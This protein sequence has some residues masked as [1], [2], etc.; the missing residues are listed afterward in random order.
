M[1]ILSS[2]ARVRVK[3]LCS[4]R[5]QSYYIS[6]QYT[7]TRMKPHP[8]NVLFLCGVSQF[9]AI[10]REEHHVIKID[11]LIKLTG[12]SRETGLKDLYILFNR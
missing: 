10:C 3:A 8:L 12:L 7:R 1:M 4:L 11:E 2:A 6:I 5:M 9:A